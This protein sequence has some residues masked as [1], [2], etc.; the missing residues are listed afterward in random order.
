V[1]GRAT[2]YITLEAAGTFGAGLAVFFARFGV[3]GLQVMWFPFL[4]LLFAVPPPAYILSMLTLPLKQGAASASTSVLAALGMPISHHGVTIIV[5]QYQLLVEDAC[6]G[7]NSILGLTAICLLY[8]YLM[9]G[10]RP[11]YALF[12][13]ALAP[14]IAIMANAVRITAIILVTYAFGDEVGQSFIH[15]LAGL[16]LF[17]AAFALVFALDSVLYP[18]AARLRKYA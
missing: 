18:I 11:A 5:A 15:E 8:I 12:L 2:D 3:K 4:Y 9:R 13:A 10:S 1:L 7:M 14:P 6:S 16:L 17:G